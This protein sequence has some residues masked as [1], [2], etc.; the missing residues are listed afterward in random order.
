[1]PDAGLNHEYDAGRGRLIPVYAVEQY[2]GALGKWFGLSDS[3]LATALPAL[4]NFNTGTLPL[5]TD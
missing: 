5:F 2:A 3:E 1:M 4:R